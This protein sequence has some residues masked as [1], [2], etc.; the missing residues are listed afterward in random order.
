[1]VEHKVIQ[2]GAKKIEGYSINLQSKNL[3]L[4]RGSKGYVM[5]GY[6]DM[7]VAEKFGDAA[8][9]ITGVATVDDAV[10]AHVHSCSS[11]ARALGISE[12]QPISDI[13]PLIC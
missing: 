10:K 2:I 7:A 13:L 4:L 1:M 12:G 6:L 9:K 5:C 11:A 8:V 3:V